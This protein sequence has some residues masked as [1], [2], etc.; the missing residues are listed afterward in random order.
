MNIIK[1]LTFCG[2]LVFTFLGFSFGQNLKVSDILA[3]HLES[4]GTKENRQRIKNR[5]AVGT[6]EFVVKIPY[7]KLAGKALL[8]SEDDN[9][10]FLSSF[11]SPDYPFERIGF[12]EKKVNIPFI[13]PGARSPLGNFLLSNGKFLGEGILTGSLSDLWFPLNSKIEKLNI[14]LAGTKKIEGRET[15]VL[16]YAPKGGFSSDSSLRLYFDSENFRHLRTEFRQKIVS[17]NYQIGILGQSAELGTG[18]LLIEDFRDFKVVDELVLPHS[19]KVFLAIDSRVGTSEFEWNI[20]FNQ[21][22]FN[23]KLDKS[24]FSFDEKVTSK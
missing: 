4:I 24:F 1:S 21:F 17:N 7:A 15:Y 14:E 3:K 18:N 23:Q 22:L 9:L 19:Y 5:M 8:A 20:N 2:L 10:F 12:F 6:S 16:S 13:K 11:N